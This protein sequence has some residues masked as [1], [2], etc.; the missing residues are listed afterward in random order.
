MS[1]LSLTNYHIGTSLNTYYNDINVFTPNDNKWLQTF[2]DNTNDSSTG[3]SAG[4]IAG[5]T[6]AGVV[7][8][9]IILFLLWRF[10]SYL[11]WLVVRIHHDIWKPR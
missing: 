5:V 4:L 8:L 10:Q 2:S 11:R 1:S 9:C 6:I 7:L 3:V